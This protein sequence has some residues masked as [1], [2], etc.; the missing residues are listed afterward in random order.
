MSNKIPEIQNINK[1]IDMTYQEL[2]N[3]FPNT[4]S[5]NYKSNLR[6]FI[7]NTMDYDLVINKE[8]ITDLIKIVNSKRC[9][10]KKVLIINALDVNNIKID[11]SKIRNT[12]SELIKQKYESNLQ[13][14]N[15]HQMALAM[16]Q[17]DINNTASRNIQSARLIRASESA[18]KNKLC[19]ATMEIKKNEMTI[20]LLKKIRYHLQYSISKYC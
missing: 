18:I 11:Y 17:Y 1:L 15:N 3:K 20:R 5:R 9:N 8:N 6:K 4:E 2:L 10:L 14:T 7:K 12:N 13:T 19:T 16:T